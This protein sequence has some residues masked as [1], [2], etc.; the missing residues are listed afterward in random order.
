MAT[1]DPDRDP[2]DEFDKL[3]P[4]QPDRVRGYPG[5]EPVGFGFRTGVR[6]AKVAV[7]FAVYAL[8]LGTI[9]VVVGAVAFSSQ[10]QWLLLGLMVLIE[11]VFILAF[12]RLLAQARRRR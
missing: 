2:W 1:Q 5:G 9:L 7:G 6:S 11:A 12:S 8:T 4:A 10:G 3:T